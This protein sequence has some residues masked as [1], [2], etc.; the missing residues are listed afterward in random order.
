M[1][2]MQTNIATANR[3]LFAVT[4]K[5][6]SDH[7]SGKR[8][9]VLSFLV[10]CACLASLYVAAS[11]I[12]STVGGEA[13][14]QVFLRLFT[15]T[16]PSL[17]FSF[18]SFVSILGSLVGIITGFD[19]I[20]GERDRGTLSRILSQPIYRDALINGKFLA[21]V[22]VLTILLIG[23]VLLVTGL[24][25]VLT[26]IPP[27]F[28]EILRILV[29]AFLSILY[30]SFW[31]AL[32]ILFSVIF[33]QTSTSA[34]ASIAIWLFLAIFAAPLLGMVAEG[35]Y[36]VADSQDTEQIVAQVQLQQ[37]LSRLTP[38]Y[39]YEEAVRTLLDPNVRTLGPISYEQVVGAIVGP[40]SL[41][42]SI[43]LIW[44]QLV[45]LIAASSICFAVAYIVFMQ[46]E[47][48]A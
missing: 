48:R 11:T 37:A 2:S 27:T 4:K 46:Q 7:L 10:V 43:L 29:Y 8:F 20:N 38:S 24:G 18:I 12:R 21:G 25:L 22:L 5:E 9:A 39:L 1:S 41:G 35:I 45:G 33:R 42:Q 36:P 6:L 19:A 40:L 34:L 23:L 16:G 28:E 17:P 44:P 26:G 3:G 47:I 31:L 13:Q 30:I 14:E 32:A 15:T